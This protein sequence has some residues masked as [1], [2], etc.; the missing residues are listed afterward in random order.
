MSVGNTPIELNLDTNQSTLIV[1]RNGA[2]KSTIIEALTFALYGRPYRNI[3]KPQLI[4]SINKSDM[5]VELTFTNNGKQYLIR[6]GMKPNIFE[7]YENDVLLKQ[8]ASTYDYQEYLEK[9]I[10]HMNYRAYVQIVILSKV[11]YT[12]FMSLKPA[13]RREVIEDMLDLVVFSNMGKLHKE[14]VDET[15]KKIQQLDNKIDSTEDKIE[16]VRKNLTKVLA[17]TEELIN[18]KQTQI[19]T[20]T[21][22]HNEA[23]INAKELNEVLAAIQLEF[24]EATTAL[25]SKSSKAN[26]LKNKVLDKQRSI[27][28]ELSF[29]DHTTKCP[30]CAQDIT[31]EYKNSIVHKRHDTLVDL[32]VALT[33]ITSRL[34]S[35]KVEKNT[36]EQTRVQITRLQNEFTAAKTTV[37][38]CKQIISSFEEEINTLRTQHQENSGDTTEIKKLQKDLKSYNKTKYELVELDN[39]HKITSYLLKDSGIKAE[40]I[41]KYIPKINEYIAKYL[42]E[43]DFFVQFEL[44]ENF[45][46][47]IKSRHRDEYTFNS[48]SEGEKMKLD[49]SMLMAWRSVAKSRNSCSTNL[50]IL[51]ELMDASGDQE[52]NESLMNIINTLVVEGNSVFVIS[53]REGLVDQFDSSIKFEKNGNFST[54]S[55]N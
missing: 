55:I 5:L 50:L 49:F 31:E 7:V 23:L 14:K 9:N 41:K 12:P 6:R 32:E 11:T 48:F 8:D 17:S 10:L 27:Q 38:S 35:V 51:D 40:M 15:K 36:H 21:T 13:Q 18:A 34:E 39:M 24:Q 26:E 44:D 25:D 46:E 4:N 22:Q 53:H 28:K 47:V 45:N 1:G 52:A 29:F 20:Y 19:E 30:T 54:M 42:S 43:L 37:K 3:N 16:F 33:K 2:S